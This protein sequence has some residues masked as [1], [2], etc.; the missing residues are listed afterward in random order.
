M[1]RSIADVERFQVGTLKI[2][3]HPTR[4]A[5]GEAAAHAAAEVMQELGKRQQPFGVIFATGASQFSTLDSLTRTPNLPWSQVRGFHL[6]EYVGI[7]PDHPASFR[8]YLRERLTAKVPM[9]EFHEINGSDPD[10][11]GVCRSYAEQLRDAAPSLCLLGIGENGHLA[12]NDP[13]IA[14]F[15]DPVDVKVVHLDAVSR[16][17]QV[18]EGWFPSVAESAERAITVTMPALFRVPRLIVSVPGKRKA[19]IIPHALAD[20]IS[21]RNPST[22]LRTHPNATLYLDHDSA[23]GLDGFRPR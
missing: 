22:I 13:G 20:D 2:E 8:K 11:E 6:D 17:Q 1:V 23:A 10:P 19:Q 16:G 9:G 12:F 4:E 21:T 14:D 7:S 5:A 18:A 3:I 15:H